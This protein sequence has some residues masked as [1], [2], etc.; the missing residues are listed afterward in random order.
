MAD[1]YVTENRQYKVID[2]MFRGNIYKIALKEDANMVMLFLGLLSLDDSRIDTMFLAADVR[3]NDI[4]G[5]PIWPRIGKPKKDK[6]G[7]S[8]KLQKMN[9]N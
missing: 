3:V 9:S 8:R 7:K 1:Q 2:I 5:N 6:S 4:D